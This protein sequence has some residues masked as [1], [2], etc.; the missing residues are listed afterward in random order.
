MALDL[1]NLAVWRGQCLHSQSTDNYITISGAKYRATGVGTL[2]SHTLSQF[3]STP[4]WLSPN[5]TVSGVPS[6]PS[7]WA[8][9]FVVRSYEGGYPALIRV[10]SS[11]TQVRYFNTSNNKVLTVFWR[12]VRNS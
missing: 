5:V 3:G 8:Y 11:N 12:L 10:S 1:D 7:G 4:F 2:A 9:E 6:A